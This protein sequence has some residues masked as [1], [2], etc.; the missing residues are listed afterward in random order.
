M[1]A[2]TRPLSITSSL[3]LLVFSLLSLHAMPAFGSSISVGVTVN[4]V[5]TGV[6]VNTSL[7]DAQVI[8]QALTPAS[9]QISIDATTTTDDRIAIISDTQTLID[10]TR[11]IRTPANAPL[12]TNNKQDWDIAITYF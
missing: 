1:D 5:D 10:V 9:V 4:F 8:L 2:V 3:I 7:A 11:P 12:E 6:R